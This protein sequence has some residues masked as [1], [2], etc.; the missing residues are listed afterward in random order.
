MR[1]SRVAAARPCG[2]RAPGTIL[3]RVSSPN[4][5]SQ[6]VADDIYRYIAPVVGPDDPRKITDS[7]IEIDAHYDAEDVGPGLERAARRARLLPLHPRH[8]RGHVP[9][10]ALDDAPVRRLLQPRGH[11]RA[12][13][14]PDR[15]RLDRPLDGLRPADPARPRLRRDD[16]RGRGRPHRRP[17]RHD[18]G[19]ADLLR[20]DPALRRLDLD[21]DQRARPRSCCCSTNSSAR[22]RASRPRTSAAPSR[23]TCSRSTWRAATT[24]TRPSRRCG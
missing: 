18:R 21:D 7:G 16:L 9:R 11:E 5:S 4:D 20:S 12:L 15:A 3:R 14:L 1:G 22:S 10:P 17:D 13:P 23:T 24:S 8:P 6:P 2:W 19:H